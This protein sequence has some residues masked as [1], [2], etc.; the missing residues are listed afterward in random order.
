[1][2]CS[3]RAAIRPRPQRRSTRA[4]TK[5]LI[6]A[7]QR[8]S[9]EAFNRLVRRHERAV[10]N[11]ALRL[12]GTAMAAEEVTQ[13]TFMRAYGALERFRGGDSAPGC[14]ASPPTAPTTNYAAASAPPAPSRS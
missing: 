5:M 8:G 14:C 3:P 6:L 12:V 1:M 13:D 9:L 7:A 4:A 2:R 10:Y 11:V